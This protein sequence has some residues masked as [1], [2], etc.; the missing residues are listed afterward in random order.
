MTNC[1][2]KKIHLF[3]ILN[4]ISERRQGFHLKKKNLYP[5]KIGVSYYPCNLVFK[6]PNICYKSV[7]NRMT[8]EDYCK[9]FVQTCICRV[10]NTSYLSL[11]KTWHEGLAHGAWTTPDRAG[12]C[13]NNKETFVKNPQ[14]YCLAKI[15]LLI[16]NEVVKT[17]WDFFHSPRTY[18]P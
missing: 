3:L 17:R 8:F 10:V 1:V 2:I 5:I 9:Y 13:P 4:Y 16:G 7:R 6:H 11:T 12:G 15:V 18:E 14:V